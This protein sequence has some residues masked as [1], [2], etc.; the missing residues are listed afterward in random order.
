V[1]KDT[2]FAKWAEGRVLYNQNDFRDITNGDPERFGLHMLI[3][4]GAFITSY[5]ESQL[6]PVLVYGIGDDRFGVS[7]LLTTPRP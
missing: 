1:H 5:G 3:V 7:I 2:P 4:I 6:K